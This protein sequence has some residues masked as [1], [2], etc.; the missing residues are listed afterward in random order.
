[1]QIMLEFRDSESLAVLEKAF[2]Q[3]SLKIQVLCRN[4]NKLLL[5]PYFFVKR[6][7]G[8]RVFHSGVPESLAYHWSDEV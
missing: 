2:F 4:A 3:L 1:M 7:Q 6:N 8:H 5:L